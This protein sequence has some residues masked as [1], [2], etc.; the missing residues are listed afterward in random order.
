MQKVAAGHGSPSNGIEKG[1]NKS[2][3]RLVTLGIGTA[4][5]GM[6][7]IVFGYSMIGG[8]ATTVSVTMV[9][10]SIGAAVGLKW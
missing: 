9:T 1:S 2:T 6:L 5:G 4:I 7:G 3:G 10:G 8:A